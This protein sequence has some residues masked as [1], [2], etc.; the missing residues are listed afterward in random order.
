MNPKLTADAVIPPAKK[1]ILSETTEK[2][3][4]VGA[5]TGGTEA[6]K[7]FMVKLPL[8]IA[9]LVIVQHMPEDFTRAFANTLTGFAV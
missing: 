6:L 3:I 9:G 8:D 2:V 5:S 4:A 1:P 7:D